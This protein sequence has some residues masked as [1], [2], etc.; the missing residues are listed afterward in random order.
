MKNLF[1]TDWKFAEFPLE[2]SFETMNQSDLPKPIDIPHDW[3]IHNVNALYRS[4]IGFYKKEFLLEPAEGHSYFVRFEGV[5][6]NSTVYLNGQMIYEWKY[7]YSTFDVDLTEHLRVGYNELCVVVTYI[8][9]NTRWYSG[10]GIYRNVYLVEK[11]ASF[12]ALDGIYISTQKNGNGFNV[13]V[14]SE[15][16]S[17]SPCNAV[18]RHTLKNRFGG[19]L[20]ANDYPVSITTDVTVNTAKFFVEN[21][22]LWDI[23]EPYLYSLESEL[24]V[25]GIVKDS[26]ANPL[27]FRT[28]RFDSNKGFFLND[29]RVQI[30]GACQH[31]D[32]G[33]LGS[34]VNKFALKRQL[35]KLMKM[36]V[37]AVRTSH[38]M[39]AV[40][41]M[42]LADEMG[43][44][45]CSEAFDMWEM[46]KTPNDYGIYFPEWYPRD[47]AS[48][49]RRDRNHPSVIMWSIGNEIYD[50]NYEKG[51]YWATTL[52]DEARKHDYMH[53]AYIGIGSNSVEWEP[54]QRCSDVLELSGYNYGERLYD[55]HHQK[56]PNWCIFGSETSSTVQSRGIYHFPYETRILTYDDGQ[57]S[58]LGN[59]TTSWGAR[60][61]DVVIS[62]HRDREFVSGQFI[63]SGWDYIG[64]PTPFFSKNSFFGQIDTAG[65]EKD[66]FYHYQ[67]E[68]TDYRV[69]P[70]VHLLPYWDFN[71]GQIIDVCAYSNA[72]YVELFF[73]GE[74]QG[75]QFIDH[76]HGTDLQGRWKLPYHEGEIKV[77]A[78]DDE[79]DIIASDSQ[80]SFTDPVA[81]KL[82]PDE[83]ALFADG[84]DMIFVEIDAIDKNG[85]FVANARNRVN[86][87]VTGAGRLV[88]LDNGDST[89][90]EEYKGTSRRLFSGKL[91]AM[92]AAKDVPG[93]IY[94][95][96]SSDGLETATLKLNAMP[97]SGV[98][99]V[100]HS[101]ENPT[102]VEKHDIPVRK[103]LLTNL[104]TTCNLNDKTRETDVEFKLFPENAT[105][106]DVTVRALTKD[107]IDANY[108]K[109]NVIGNKA[110]VT[111]LGDG[112]FR[113]VACCN[114]DKDHPEVMSDLEFSIEGLGNANRNAYEF[115]PGIEFD[116]SN[117]P[118]ASELS[119]QGGVILPC[120]G[121]GFITYH[122]ID[123]GS[124]GSNEITIPIFSF[125]DEVELEIW[126]GDLQT[127][128]CLCKDT[129]R[130]KSW[131]NHYQDN[132]FKLTRRVCGLT[133]ITLVFNIHER[134]SVKGFV[135]TKQ[136][137]AYELLN[138][139][140]YS[141]ISGDS[142]TLEKEAVTN[143][144]NNVSIDFD[145]MNFNT[146]GVSSI[147]I[148]GRSHN[149]VTSMHIV[150]TEGDIQNRQ[151]VE[152]PYSNDYQTYHFELND[153][154]LNG[155]LSL[156]FLPGTNFDLKEFKFYPIEN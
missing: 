37:N 11:E 16:V 10:A 102:S 106:T 150:V 45:I 13:T 118:Q 38:N 68:W 50:T 77:Y 62:A 89:D 111:A 41:L 8:E 134:L 46:P 117:D 25:D 26:V 74:S 142:F 29:K 65:F 156:I 144:G 22:R 82:I 116:N 98:C 71:E 105:Y 143:I 121:R 78:Y 34:A 35:K 133:S 63:W 53:N 28:I 95:T 54:A 100:C 107:A 44:L 23:T 137:K 61:T 3:M 14:D 21:P 36:G 131:Y 85:T 4:S 129:Y 49:I 114:N 43:L 96:A 42:D 152:I 80:R 31:Q 7:G 126:E 136:E 104:G 149:P 51:V 155:T 33:A 27:G 88:G 139:T 58:C 83:E 17:K 127:G 70:M 1:V 76:A 19:I 66:T 15:T 103:I 113:L 122:N 148:C 93:D 69:S 12:F 64:E 24:I 75:K 120:E 145:G 86:V 101:F 123:F 128:E 67:A 108:V 112:A 32:L 40:E 94:I 115:I 154:R 59:C 60:N 81:L 87:S 99:H 91:L 138:A 90:Y 72:P 130:A 5:Y 84:E 141:H 30:N 146:A 48:W 110:H 2:T 147:D 153:I 55:E 57:C 92:I 79:G 18:I 52:R 135:F 97:S 132:T 56:F 6:M 73:N 119:F 124:F 20:T 39:P 140:D 47:I 151:K 9:P 109:I 125:H